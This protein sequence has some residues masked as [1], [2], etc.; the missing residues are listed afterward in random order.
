LGS[1]KKKKEREAEGI[2]E[3]ILAENFPNLGKETGIKIQETER[4][5]LKINK[6]RSTPRHLIVKLTSLR[7]KEKILKAAQDKRSVTCNGRNIRLAADPSTETWQARKGWHDILRA[8]NEKNIQPR[9]LYPARLSF[10]MEGELKTF[11]DKQKLKEFVI[12]KLALQEILK[13]IL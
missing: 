3:H 4:N 2:L 8:L 10:R 13:G 12:I 1:Q 9:L 7:D 11:Q 5:L 6:N